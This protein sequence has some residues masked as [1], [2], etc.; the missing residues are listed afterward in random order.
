MRNVILT[1]FLALVLLPGV[2]AGGATEPGK[3]TTG[4]TQPAASAAPAGKYKEAPVLAELVKAGRLPPVEQRLPEKPFVVE[5]NT[6]VKGEDLKV[7]IGKYGGPSFKSITTNSSLDWNLRDAAMENWL[8]SPAHTT[9]PI[10]GN[11]AESFSVND[12]NTVFTLTIRK[13]LKWSDGEPVTT[14]DVRFGWEDVML[15]KEITPIVPSNYRAGGK[16]GAEVAKLEILDQYT[17]RITF[18]QPYGRFFD[19]LGLGNLWGSYTDIMKPAHYL[20]K[21]HTKYTP[22]EKMAADLKAANLTEKEWF[23]LFQAKDIVWSEVTNANAAGFPTLG[24]WVPARFT[25]DR[26]V[27]E[28]NPYYYKVDMAGN[29]LPYVDRYEAVI[30]ADPEV[31]P[32]KVIAGEVNLNR[33]LIV[34]DKVPLLKDNEAKGNYKV[35]LNFTYHNAPI[36]LFLNYNNS[37]PVWTEVVLN[38]KFRQAIN[39]GMNTKGLLDT[40]FLGMGKREP[41]FPQEYNVAKANALLDEMGMNKRDGEGYRLSP[42]GKRFEFF[43]EYKEEAADWQRMAE[44]IRA[45]IEKLGLRTPMKKLDNA[46]WTQRRNASE[47]Y[48]TIDWLDDV[49]WPYLKY[50]YTGEQR[51]MW[52]IK[53]HNWIFTNGKEGI[54]PPD[55][56]KELYKID[57]ELRAVK[58]GSERAAASEK[59]FAAWMMEYI[60]MFPVARDVVSPMVV[61]TNLGNLATKGRS[62]ATQFAAEIYY[63]K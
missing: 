51:C 31:I 22:V 7:E 49:N 18:A 62:S 34:H 40:V 3:A 29:Q 35:N 27:M 9:G 53:W 45:D 11:I 12:D 1:L 26:M 36:A 25:P 4:T 17:F 42:S 44:V 30:V 61:P 37:D 2:W 39:L 59:K 54:E 63:Y 33:D 24:P 21:F 5:Q 57:E 19:I 28:R 10:F 60:P 43:F 6:L 47:L 56:I 55:W 52:G 8:G 14:D 23:R 48:A 13:G 15:N 20:K 46:L 50:D 58:P 32:L 41:W 38:K 16:A